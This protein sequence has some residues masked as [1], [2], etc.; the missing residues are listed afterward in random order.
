MLS[1]KQQDILNKAKSFSPKKE[2]EGSENYEVT[3]GDYARALAQGL[4]FGF[5]EEVEAGLKSA[6]GDKTYEE[7][8]AKIRGE[9][10][11]FREQDPVAAYGLEIAGSLPTMFVPGVGAARGAQ[12]LS[13]LGKATRA[14][15]SGALGGGLYGAG[16]AESMAD[17]PQS[18]ATGAALGGVL[19]GATTAAF[20]AASEAA[21]KLIKEGVPLTPGQALGGISA[22]TEG[23]LSAFP[24]TRQIV[25]G[26]KEAAVQGFGRATFNKALAPIGKRVSKSLSGTKAFDDAIEAVSS[27]YDEIIPKIA[28]DKSDEMISSLNRAASQASDEFVLTETTQP[29]LNGILK[30]ITA[31][32]PESGAVKGE[33]L[34]RIESKL[35]AVA[36][37]RL[38]SSSADDKVIGLALFDVQEAF[39]NELVRQNPAAREL[40]NVNKAFSSLVPIQKAVNKA[41]ASGGDFTPKQLV[42]SVA[43]GSRRKAARGKADLQEFATI[44]QEVMAPTKGGALVAPLTG[45]SI[46]ADLMAGKVSPLAKLIGTGL[47]TAPLYSQTML[48]VTR[49]LLASPGYA[50]RALA[51]ATGGLLSPSAS[52]YISSMLEE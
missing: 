8:V 3:S 35:G 9:M 21:K 26:A 6:F 11:S 23:V 19:G 31:D 29:I 36:N 34:K 5:G 30:K 51:P 22:I 1:Q 37:Q 42:E 4:T 2:K 16:T 33:I 47:A 52:D 44:G 32:L 45:V 18:V 15:I 41:I 14:G 38:K 7:E 12:A 20:P 24:V 43:Q 40:Q 50:G 17:I 49:G 46:A 27:K 48:P 28:I 10:E 25:E 13:K 39:R